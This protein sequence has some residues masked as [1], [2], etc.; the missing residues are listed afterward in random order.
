MEALSWIILVGFLAFLAIIIVSEGLKR[1]GYCVWCGKFVGTVVMNRIPLDNAGQRAGR[2]A[3][4]VITN[5]D[6]GW[7][8]V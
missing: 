6:H 5:C 4:L 3:H 2:T 7:K 8:N 1:M